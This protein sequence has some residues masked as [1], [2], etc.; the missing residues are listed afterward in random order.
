MHH[1]VFSLLYVAVLSVHV[2]VLQ[3][4]DGWRDGLAAGW[5]AL[6]QK[7][8]DALRLMSSVDPETSEASESAELVAG[9][10]VVRKVALHAVRVAIK[11][12]RSFWKSHVNMNVSHVSGWLPLT[13]RMR[14]LHRVSPKATSGELF[15]VDGIVKYR[16]GQ[17]S[18][19]DLLK[20]ADHARLAMAI[21]SLKPPRSL[22]DYRHSVQHLS[23][24]CGTLDDIGALGDAGSY[25][26]L[27]ATRAI[28]IAEM[29]AN[30]IDGLKVDSATTAT[31]L[32][33]MFPDMADWASRHAAATHGKQ[34]ISTVRQLVRRVQWAGPVE[35][36]TCFLC[37][38]SN[39]QVLN[40]PASLI[41][42]LQQEIEG[43]RKKLRKKLGF[44]A[45]PVRVLKEV[46]ATFASRL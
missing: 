6:P 19:L 46:T 8:K 25:G 35:L 18:D 14:I 39:D 10:K 32:S 30:G 37:V 34:P 23:S 4:Q 38:I 3:R 11:R 21:R 26:F 42:S 22:A 36:L 29:R 9:A 1:V 15:K 44:E 20:L 27:W 2:G 5:K 24:T 33:A 28:T 12:D 43:V 45:H 13:L 40:M 31:S 7:E 17:V 16:A 41:Q